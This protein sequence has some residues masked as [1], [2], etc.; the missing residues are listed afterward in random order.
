MLT[1]SMAQG[2]E[3]REKYAVSFTRKL[4]GLRH[5]FTP[6]LALTRVSCSLNLLAPNVSV[7]TLACSVGMYND[8]NGLN[9]TG[10]E[11]GAKLVYFKIF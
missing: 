10:K 4:N 3:N 6:K 1:V 9:C 8:Q 7:L 5:N 11:K 2:L